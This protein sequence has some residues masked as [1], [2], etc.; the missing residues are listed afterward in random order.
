MAAAVAEEEE[1]EEEEEG[2]GETAVAVV[3]TVLMILRRVDGEFPTNI[4]LLA[5]DAWCSSEDKSGRGEV[6]RARFREI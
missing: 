2:A 4:P 3:G 6:E 5:P 1:E